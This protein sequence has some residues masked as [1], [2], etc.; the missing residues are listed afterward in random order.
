[1]LV[2]VTGILAECTDEAGATAYCIDGTVLFFGD[3]ATLALGATVSYDG[4]DLVETNAEEL[5]GVV[6]S[7]LE[8]TVLV[9]A[10]TSPLVVHAINGAVYPVADV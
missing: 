9:E 10:G 5:A 4:D 6:A 1:V 2:E 8:V 7:G 3:A